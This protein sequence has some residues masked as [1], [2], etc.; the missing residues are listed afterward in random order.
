MVFGRT[1][2]AVQNTIFLQVIHFVSFSLPPCLFA[3]GSKMKWP[4][5]KKADKNDTSPEI[6]ALIKSQTAKNKC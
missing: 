3:W 4:G 2:L 1:F 5:D 6:V